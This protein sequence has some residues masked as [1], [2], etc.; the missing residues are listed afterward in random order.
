VCSLGSRAQIKYSSMHRRSFTW[1]YTSVAS[2]PMNHTFPWHLFSGRGC[3]APVFAASGMT[4]LNQMH[5][6]GGGAEREREGGRE[7]GRREAVLYLGKLT[8]HIN[9]SA[10]VPGM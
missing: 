10:G 2:L 6:E 4:T 7:G 5:Q 1:L 3:S 9:S 8:K